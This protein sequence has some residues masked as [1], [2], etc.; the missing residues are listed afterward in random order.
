MSDPL[1]S[2]WVHQI[3]LTRFGGETSDAPSFDAPVT[4]AGFVSDETKLIRDATGTEVVSSA[5]V[6]LPADTA[7]VA[8]LSKVKLPDVFG[9]RTARVMS[10]A[11]GDGGGQP[12]PDHIV[13]YLE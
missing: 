4:I 2:W 9:G 6:A 12:T 3:V 1:A 8:P 5:Q 7:Y 13:L 11:V 10:T